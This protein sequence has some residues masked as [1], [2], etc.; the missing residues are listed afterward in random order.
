[1]K[2]PYIKAFTMA[3][4]LVTMIITGIIF[5]CVMEGFGL[6]TRYAGR[7]E[8]EILKGVEIYTNHYRFDLLLESCDTLY[9]QND[10]TIIMVQ[11][12]NQS[13]LILSDSTLT[14]ETNEKKDT[15]FSDVEALMLKKG[16]V[17]YSIDTIEV[18]LMEREGKCKKNI[19]YIKDYS[20]IR[21]NSYD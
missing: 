18:V 16:V 20:I 17:G 8:K 10:G 1:M 2:S 12:K 19:R 5:L 15:I 6:F 13:A 14:L 3:E 9:S 21:N 11:D 4:L 7:Q